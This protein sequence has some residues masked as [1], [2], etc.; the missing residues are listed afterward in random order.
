[1]AAFEEGGIVSWEVQLSGMKQHG[2]RQSMERL[3]E[4]YMQW[5]F[6]GGFNLAGKNSRV[7]N[8]KHPF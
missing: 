6:T 5:I 8:E 3:W 7:W 2:S 1:M 4:E